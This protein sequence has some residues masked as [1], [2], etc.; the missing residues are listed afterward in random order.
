VLLRLGLADALTRISGPHRDAVVATI[1][2]ERTYVEAAEELRVP[3]GT[4]KS[5]VHHGLR[6]LRT[7]LDVAA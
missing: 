1:L 3:V 5:R 2:R 7:I 4:V 6:H